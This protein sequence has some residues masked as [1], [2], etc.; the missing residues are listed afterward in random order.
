VSLHFL[1]LLWLA[2][3]CWRSVAALLQLLHALL[4]FHYYSVATYIYIMLWRPWRMLQNSANWLNT[5]FKSQLFTTGRLQNS[6]R[7]SRT[8]W[9]S[10]LF[11][12]SFQAQLCG[13][14][15]G[16]R[17]VGGTTKQTIQPTKPMRTKIYVSLW[18]DT[19][20]LQNPSS[21]TSWSF[22]TLSEFDTSL[23][24]KVSS[25]F[26]QGG[27]CSSSPESNS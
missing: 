5:P 4:L 18:Y 19:Q 20:Y 24:S 9:K 1:V 10:Q 12:F 2:Q 21:W 23:I 3:S 7:N 11:D 26:E 13:L 22:K 16:H 8:L 25:C 27:S 15:H 6:A 17:V 14:L